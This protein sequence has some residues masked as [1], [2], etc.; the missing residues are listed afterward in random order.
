M[1]YDLAKEDGH[2]VV[3][4]KLRCLQCDIPKFETVNLM[5]NYSILVSSFM[6]G[7]GDGYKMLVSQRLDYENLGKVKRWNLKYLICSLSI[8][9]VR[10]LRRQ[11]FTVCR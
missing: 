6:A 11:L 9:C 3:D 4:L 2:R 1:K 5:A 8:T 7:G 10:T